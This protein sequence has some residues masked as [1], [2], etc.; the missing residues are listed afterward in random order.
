M[1]RPANRN[2]DPARAPREKRRGARGRSIGVALLL[3]LA[4]TACTRAGAG[5]SSGEP[6]TTAVPTAPS[7]AGGDREEPDGSYTY[8][9]SGLTARF[10]LRAS[11]G[12]L[13]VTNA[14]GGRIPRPDL[15]FLDARDGT[16]V[17]ADV[18]GVASVGDGETVTLDVSVAGPLAAKNVGLVILEIA[19][20]NWG[21]F[22]P[23]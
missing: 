6:V 10:V 13:T 7:P 18:N 16:R 20:A 23:M 1:F 11:G 17:E 3:L 22:S 9:S 19:G 2:G 15:Y 14:T 5:S 4:G 21:A 8:A 12:T